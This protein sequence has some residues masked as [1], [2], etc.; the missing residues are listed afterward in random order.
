M[1]EEETISVPFCVVSMNVCALWCLRIYRYGVFNVCK[2][3]GQGGNEN[4]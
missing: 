4:V 1:W 3:E 2:Y